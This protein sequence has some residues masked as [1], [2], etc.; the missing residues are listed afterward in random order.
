M[1]PDWTYAV[2]QAVTVCCCKA[3]LAQ[4]A[5]SA[6]PERLMHI[7]ALIE[8]I[9]LRSLNSQQQCSQLHTAVEDSQ[10]A[11]AYSVAATTSGDTMNPVMALSCQMRVAAARLVSNLSDL[12]L[13]VV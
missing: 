3:K 11:T 2:A 7:Q 10:S 13:S 4:V 5:M 6:S 1:L 12:R 9:R 8:D